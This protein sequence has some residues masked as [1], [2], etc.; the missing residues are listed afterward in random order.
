MGVGPAIVFDFEGVLDLCAQAWSLADDLE[1]YGTTR[2]TALVTALEDWK[3][4]EATTM[5]Q[6]VWPAESANLTT[7]VEQLRQGALAWAEQ[8]RDAQTAYNMREYTA[9]I[10]QEKSTRST[11][12]SLWDGFIGQDDSAKHVPEP[13]ASAAP[14]PPS[15]EAPTGFV[16]Y[17]QHSHSDWSASYR[18]FHR[19]GGSRSW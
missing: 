6:D 12:E 10:E 15:F 19:G 2:D 11:G 1:T 7:G 9:A 4:P 16:S 8:W 18:M 14:A 5:V 13:A 3:G 17:T